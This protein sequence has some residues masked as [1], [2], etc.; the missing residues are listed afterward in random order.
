MKPLGLLF[1]LSIILWLVTYAVSP[2]YPNK[3][4]RLCLRPPAFYTQDVK[5]RFCIQDGPSS[6]SRPNI[7]LLAL[8]GT[9]SAVADSPTNTSHYTVGVLSIHSLLQNITER[10]SPCVNVTAYQIMSLDSIDMNSSHMI[11]MSRRVN[12][13]LNNPDVTGVIL[14]GGTDA[15]IEYLTFIA[16]TVKSK[17]PIIGTGAYRPH[18]AHDADGLQNIVDAVILAATEGWSEDYYEVA[19]VMD[20]D[21]F[22]LWG[23]RKENDRFV[24]G[25]GSSI[26]RV[27]GYRVS[28]HDL[29]GRPAPF[30]FDMTE[31]SSVSLLPV[32]PIFLVHTGFDYKALEK[33][34]DEGARGLI[35]G[36]YGNGYIP[37]TTGTAITKLAY[38]K[39]IVVMGAGVNSVAVTYARVKGMIPGQDWDARQLRILTQLYLVQG[40]GT[41]KHELKKGLEHGAKPHISAE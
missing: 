37:A 1:F 21:I 2:P 27:E 5:D 33:A 14:L 20:G 6:N 35:I 18:T 22:R 4:D 28:F 19:M 25:F 38:E 34:V 23:T 11:S 13:E 24:P 7:V 15:M 3:D 17:K 29:P 41:N 16:L 36:V 12:K 32:V 10:W 30:K 9:V 40:K 31:F 39:D 26:G 8:G